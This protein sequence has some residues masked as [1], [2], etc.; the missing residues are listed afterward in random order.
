MIYVMKHYYFILRLII[1]F[2]LSFIIGLDRKLR[3][4]EVGLR[5]NI[6]VCVRVF[7]FVSTLFNSYDENYCSSNF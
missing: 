1:C 2:I 7:L 5:T 3:E 6:I 4:S